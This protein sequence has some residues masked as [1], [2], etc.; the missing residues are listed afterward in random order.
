MDDVNQ[1]ILMHLF[2]EIDTQEDEGEEPQEQNVSCQNKSDS[3]KKCSYWLSQ[4]LAE[5]FELNKDKL[6]SELLKE[7]TEELLDIIET[8]YF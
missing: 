1:S 3:Q 2:G 4:K 6:D 8:D 7:L 5:K